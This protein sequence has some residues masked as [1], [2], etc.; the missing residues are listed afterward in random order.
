MLSDLQIKKLTRYFHV[1]DI[2]DDGRIAATDFERI[3]ENVKMLHGAPDG[4]PG[5]RDVYVNLWERIRGAD[6]DGDGT[7]DLDEWLAY[8]QLA[9]EDDTRYEAEVEEL[10]ERVFRIFDLDEDDEIGPSEF[11]DFYGVFGLAVSLSEA[12]FSSLDEN[13]DGVLTRAELQEIG[14]EFFGRD[15]A[16]AKGN[17]LFGPFGA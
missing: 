9:L 16:E 3:V 4:A 13:G 15:D 11:A 10:T 6:G 8:W 5:L 2:D 14:R 1:Y 7:I 12:V 17:L